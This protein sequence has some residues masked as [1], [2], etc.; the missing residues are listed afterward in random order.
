MANAILYYRTPT[1]LSNTTNATT[2]SALLAN[3]NSQCLEFTFS[4]NLLE[5]IQSTYTNNVVD[6]PVPNSSGTRKINKQDN[7]VKSLSLIIK[8]RFK[9]PLNASGVPIIDTEINKLIAISKILQVGVDHPFGV[10][11]FYSPNAPQ[12]SLDP[13][14]TSDNTGSPQSGTVTPAT[15]GYTISSWDLGY[16]SPNIT[17]YDFSVTL[18]YG[19]TW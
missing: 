2:P 12:F 17:A 18:S 4:D 14:A 9:K 8:G 19:G 3:F 13:N 6:Y 15:K 10:V 11:G 1:T 16:A 7:G 5:S